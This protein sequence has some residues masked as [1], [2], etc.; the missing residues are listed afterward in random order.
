MEQDFKDNRSLKYVFTPKEK[1]EIGIELANKTQEQRSLEDEKKSIT[2]TYASRI[3]EAKEQITQAAN[4]VASG[5]ELR[6]IE[7]EVQ[8]HIP[9]EGMKTMTRLDIDENR[10]GME[11]TWTEKM[12]S[13]D[14]NLWTQYQE[15]NAEVIEGEEDDTTDPNKRIESSKDDDVTEVDFEETSESQDKRELESAKETGSF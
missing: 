4:K 10:D 14:Y 9:K 13:M 1:E 7:C 12:N 8:Y 5:Y 15:D 6:Q 2:S 3:N 11:E